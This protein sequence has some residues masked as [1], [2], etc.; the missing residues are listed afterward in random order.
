MPDFSLR[1]AYLLQLGEG[2]PHANAKYPIAHTLNIPSASSNAT[3]QYLGHWDSAAADR[4]RCFHWLHNVSLNVTH[5][6]PAAG[7]ANPQPDSHFFLTI[8][9]S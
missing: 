8:S 9:P 5:V 2:L 6:N 7:E 4:D 1:T 3:W